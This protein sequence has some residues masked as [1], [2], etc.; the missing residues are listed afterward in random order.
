LFNQL[1]ILLLDHI[2]IVSKHTVEAAGFIFIIRS[3]IIYKV[4]TGP[5]WRLFEKEGSILSLNP[6]FYQF[7]WKNYKNGV[8]MLP[9]F[10]RTCMVQECIL[11]IIKY[12]VYFC[13]INI[14]Y[15]YNIGLLTVNIEFEASPSLFP[16][17]APNTHIYLYASTVH[18]YCIYPAILNHN[19]MY[20]F[21]NGAHRGILFS[22][23]YI[24]LFHI[25]LSSSSKPLFTI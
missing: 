1:D 3:R 12:N 17:F 10:L 13:V 21:Q 9:Q 20:V 25:L 23:T 5:L 24:Q 18:M 22:N 8:G 2:I 4:I 16:S 11:T 6:Y 7:W 15:I 19:C 14:Q